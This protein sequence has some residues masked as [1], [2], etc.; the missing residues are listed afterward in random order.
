MNAEGT[1]AIED[2]SHI[3]ATGQVIGTPS[4]MPPEQARGNISLIGPASDVYS[5]GAILYT[6]LSGHPP[7]QAATIADTLMQVLNKEP[8]PLRQAN[9]NLPVDLET[10][11]LKCLQKDINKRYATAA[12]V[13][14]E[15]E[16]F[17]RGEPIHARP[18]SRLER[19]WRWCR[20]A[21][22]SPSRPSRRRCG[23]RG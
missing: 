5:L 11:C 14:A 12:E 19:G 21:S 23:G 2:D 1:I 22:R 3:T 17:L 8:I 10:I 16:R 7:F 18:I 15:L 13:K 6:L 20:T 4:Y 9:S